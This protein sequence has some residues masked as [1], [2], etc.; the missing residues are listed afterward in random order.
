VNA[1]P[2][3]KILDQFCVNDQVT[4]IRVVGEI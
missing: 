3:N 2:I 4:T 1:I